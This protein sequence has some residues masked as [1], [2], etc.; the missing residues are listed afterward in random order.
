M[1]HI[2]A[3]KWNAIYSSG[4]YGKYEPTRILHDY[5]H[6]LPKSGNALDV[7]CGTGSNALFLAR[8]GLK[9]SAWDISEQA[10]KILNEK[11][12][13]LGIH[14]ETKICD[15][16]NEPPA[17]NSFDVIVVSYFLERKLIPELIKALN[18]EGLLFYQTFSRERIDDTGPSNNDYRLARNELLE[19]CHNLKIILYHEEGLVG[20]TQQ[21]FRNEVM[22]IG[23]R[24]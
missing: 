10:I 11:A 9:V 22:L 8:H 5:A 2:D 12:S 24:L 14:I 21:G 3:E 4:K 1:S 16:V 7:A 17:E 20:N 13:Q 19:L 6:L 18:Y 15:V 23:Q